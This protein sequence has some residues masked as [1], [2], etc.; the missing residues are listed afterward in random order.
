MGLSV[1]Y[2]TKLQSSIQK[3]ALLVEKVKLG[4][5]MFALESKKLTIEQLIQ[6]NEE[7]IASETNDEMKE[8]CQAKIEAY[9]VSLDVLDQM[10]T[11]IKTLSNE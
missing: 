9:K 6:T 7:W 5:V 11:Q 10:Y 8:I 1:D 4:D 2:F 3:N